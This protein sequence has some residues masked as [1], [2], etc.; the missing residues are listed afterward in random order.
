MDGYVSAAC[1]H[2]ANVS[3]RLGK[4]SSP[5][6]ISAA[7]KPSSELSDAFERCSEYLRKNG[8]DLS[9]TKATLGPWVT[10]DSK[11]QRFVQDFAEGA[12]KLSER[13]VPRAFRS[14]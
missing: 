14:A 10:F 2:M 1:C 11:Q 6:S 9:T 4:P 12:N 7:I 8:V 3:H 5:E 13:Q